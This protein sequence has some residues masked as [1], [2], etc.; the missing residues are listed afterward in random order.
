MS[1]QLRQS[2]LF[3]GRHGSVARC[4]DNMMAKS[5]RTTRR[6]GVS[7]RH[8]TDSRNPS[9]CRLSTGTRA[10]Y[11]A[12]VCTVVQAACAGVVAQRVETVVQEALPGAIGPALRYDVAVAGVSDAA[13]RFERVHIIG[14]R[15]AR[16]GVPVFDRVEG[17]LNGVVVNRAEKRLVSIGSAAVLADLLANDVASY[18]ASRGLIEDA[19]VSF[20]APS[21]FVATGRIK[22][23]GTSLSSA[24]SGEFRGNLQAAG[25]QLRLNVESLAFGPVAAPALLRSALEVA[26]IPLVDLSSFAVP[27]RIDSIQVDG[28]K[29]QIRASGVDLV[30][31]QRLSLFRL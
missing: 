18:M 9:V 28:E 13:N 11:A 3:A 8:P 30:A 21:S 16:Q 27:S 24:A 31:N 5:F 22:I 26:I 19:K 17:D 1:C 23:P 20:V 4:S 12:L 25:S 15:V 14:D 6:S 7:P 29:L 10:G 2:G